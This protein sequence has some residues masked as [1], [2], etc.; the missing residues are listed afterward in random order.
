MLRGKTK[1]PEAPWLLDDFGM[2]LNNRGIFAEIM[3][4]HRSYEFEPSALSTCVHLVIDNSEFEARSIMIMSCCHA[5]P[6]LCCFLLLNLEK[7]NQCVFRLDTSND[8]Q[9]KSA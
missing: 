9:G 8:E 3:A 1:G 4:F 5:A 2:P 7:L 6:V